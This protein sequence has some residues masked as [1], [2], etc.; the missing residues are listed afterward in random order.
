MST[1]KGKTELPEDYEQ[2]KASANRGSSWR[3]RLRAVEELGKWKTE[4]TISVL[5]HRLEQDPV[6]QVQEAAYRKLKGLG[7]EAKL[8]PRKKGELIKGA[9]KVMVRVRKSLPEGHT[10]EDFKEKLRKMRLDVYDA[11]EGEKGDE[12]DAWLRTQWTTPSA[13]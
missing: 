2:W 11:Y 7:V 12:F 6:Y 10:F 3:E 8:P 1:I 5:Q 4:Q 13:K 9:G